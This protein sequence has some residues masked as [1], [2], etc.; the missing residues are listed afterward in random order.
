MKLHHSIENHIIYFRRYAKR[1]VHIWRKVQNDIQFPCQKEEIFHFK[2]IWIVYVVLCFD[3]ISLNHTASCTFSFH[4]YLRLGSGYS[5][6][7]LTKIK[8]NCVLPF[9]WEMLFTKRYWLCSFVSVSH[10][11]WGFTDKGCS[12]LRC[13]VDVDFLRS[14]FF[15]FVAL[16]VPAHSITHIYYLHPIILI[17]LIS[18]R[19]YNCPFHSIRYTNTYIYIYYTC[20]S[21]CLFYFHRRLSMSPV[22]S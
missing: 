10:S 2:Y 1:K 20:M 6:P 22:S 8:I 4:S 3:M 13:R 18:M 11:L 21:V 9:D 7:K 19:V 17:V 16:P 5:S 15:F 12:V 14:F